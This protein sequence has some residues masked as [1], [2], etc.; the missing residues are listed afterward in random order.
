MG[1]LNDGGQVTVPAV[2]SHFSPTFPADFSAVEIV[3]FLPRVLEFV[4]PPYTAE[5]FDSRLDIQLL[6]ATE[7]PNLIEG[8]GITSAT[9][10]TAT[11]VDLDA[12]D[13]RMSELGPNSSLGFYD[14]TDGNCVAVQ[15][16]RAD[17]PITLASIRKL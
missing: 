14:V 16:I 13:A 5:S 8:L 15:E 1:V 6:V 4:E 3:S 10:Q 7:S 12:I 11:P 9:P 2:E 17:A